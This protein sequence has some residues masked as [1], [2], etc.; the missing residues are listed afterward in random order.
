VS[1]LGI[2]GKV[3]V[4]WGDAEM[5]TVGKVRGCLVLDTNRTTVGQS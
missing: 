5:A 4:A 3:L 1:V 2:C